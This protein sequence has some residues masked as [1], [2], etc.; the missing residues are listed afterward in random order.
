M[1]DFLGVSSHLLKIMDD[2]ITEFVRGL[3][4]AGVR[5]SLAEGLDAFRAIQL[6]GVQD[7]VQFRE[8]LRTTL[9]KEEADF[10]VFDRLFPLYFTGGDI[11]LQDAS[12]ELNDDELNSLNE[13]LSGMDDQMKQ[14]LEWLTSGDA[15]SAE[16]LE[17][18]AQA[19]SE[20]R[21]DSSRKE[22]WVTRDM[23]NALG[24]DKLEETM[25]QLMQKLQEMGMRPE[26]IEQLLGITR[27]NAE[28]MRDRIAE[29]VGLEVQRE[30]AEKSGNGLGEGAADPFEDDIMNR[31]F[32]QLSEFD[33]D[34]LRTEVRRLVQQLRTRAA[35]RR[36]RDRVG[37]FDP[38]ATI[39]ANQRYGGVPIELKF[40][41]KKQKPSLIFLVDVSGSMERIV[42]F[43]LRFMH[44]LDDQVG[45]V[46]I[47]TYYAD[48]QE[49]DPKISELVA[50]NEVVDAFYLLRRVHPYRPYSTDLGRGLQTFFDQHLFTVDQRST[51]VFLGDGRNN[52]KNP[53]T[54]L[55]K[56]LQ[57][58]A[59][60]LIWLNPEAQHKWRYDD[61]DMGQYARWCDNVH[62]VQNLAQLSN[63]IDRLLVA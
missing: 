8:S 56:E 44:Q 62:I 46:R 6:L 26:A 54:D 51:V 16:E 42:E 57:R 31:P 55:V 53:R 63:A 41:Q 45:K 23:L 17:A 61:S 12:A 36:K 32:D 25:M 1:V 15:P 9:V 60:R 18:L 47:F 40:K 19:M 39:R 38:K 20:R 27:Q 52:Y 43:L 37:K 4:T 14:L 58:R 59:K 24:F 2:R 21:R 10:D 28:T 49:L 7:R 50:R 35:L 5:V 22:M 33:T 48:L 13:A 11:P 30:R 3:R 34:Q 29:M